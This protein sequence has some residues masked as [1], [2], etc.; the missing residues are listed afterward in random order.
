M[1]R[2]KKSRFDG[3]S[4]GRA[5]YVA[6][7]K[8]RERVKVYAPDADA[9]TVA[10]AKAWGEKWPAYEFYAFCEVTPA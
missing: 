1:A 9:A 10:A 3:Y 8:H 2:Q 4:G 6:H 7:P 5:Y